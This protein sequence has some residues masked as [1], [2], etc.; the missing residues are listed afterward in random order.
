MKQWL[1]DIFLCCA[2]TATVPLW[3]R[4]LGL[5]INNWSTPFAVTIFIIGVFGSSIFQTW[6]D[7]EGK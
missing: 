2:A 3:D 5:D 6:K 4:Y 1:S 7:M